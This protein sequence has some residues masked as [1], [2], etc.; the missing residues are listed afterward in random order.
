M[1]EEKEAQ[2]D[3]HH[4]NVSGMR[5]FKVTL[6]YKMD[7]KERTGFINGIY[8]GFETWGQKKSYHLAW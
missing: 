7:G 2:Q 5:E 6:I 4:V 1:E 3:F 8:A